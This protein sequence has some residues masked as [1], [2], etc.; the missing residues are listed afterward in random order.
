MMACRAVAFSLTRKMDKKSTAYLD[1][2]LPL[3]LRLLLRLL[4]L[5]CRELG[6]LFKGRGCLKV[7]VLALCGV[8]A[9][10]HT[11]FSAACRSFHAAFS[12]S[13]RAL[14][15]FSSAL[16]RAVC[17]AASS[18]RRMMEAVVTA[19]VNSSPACLIASSRFWAASLVRCATSFSY[20]AFA[21]SSVAASLAAALA[22]AAA[23][24]ASA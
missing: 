24:L 13:R 6:G 5:A 18:L 12:A 17:A 4:A 14:A 19:L 20:S 1:S 9:T 3:T 11:S 8:K 16:T 21:F 2:I 15:A 23:A 10:P 22:L 7:R